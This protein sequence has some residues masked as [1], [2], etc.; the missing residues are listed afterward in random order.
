MITAPGPY[1]P[2]PTQSLTVALWAELVL[3][4][5]A[6]IQRGLH[7]Y[8]A[9]GGDPRFGDGDEAADLEAQ[10]EIC[11]ECPVAASCL[12]EAL[13]TE[14]SR[15]VIAAEMRA[16]LTARQRDRLRRARRRSHSR[17]LAPPKL[18]ELSAA[19]R[20]SFLEAVTQAIDD[21]KTY[22]DAVHT[23]GYSGREGQLYR[24][25]WRANRLDLHRLLRSNRDS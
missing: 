19:S 17:A 24:R 13:E 2:R 9:C 1:P 3:G 6:P 15:Y 20:S 21:G 12:R 10:R 22:S 18:P 23:L 7:R 14:E 4:P 25:L 11:S 16:G 8:A 5:P